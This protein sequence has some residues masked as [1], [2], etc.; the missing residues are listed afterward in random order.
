MEAKV[1]FLD[2]IFEMEILMDL[3]VLRSP[4]SENYVFSGLCTSVIDVTKKKS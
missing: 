3:D 4:K 1:L 2:K